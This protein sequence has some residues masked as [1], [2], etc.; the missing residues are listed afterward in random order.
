MPVAPSLKKRWCDPTASLFEK[1][2]CDAFQTLWTTAIDAK[3]DVTGENPETPYIEAM[4]YFVIALLYSMIM[5][6]TRCCACCACNRCNP[7]I[8]ML[9]SAVIMVVFI[10]LFHNGSV[11]C[12]IAAGP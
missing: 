4:A 8:C 10:N 9:V 12:R 2:S 5:V 7:S 6:F 1:G 11:P 3:A